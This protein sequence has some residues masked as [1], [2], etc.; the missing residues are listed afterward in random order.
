MQT[1]LRESGEL[2]IGYDDLLHSRPEPSV[3][4]TRDWIE[5]WVDVFGPQHRLLSIAVHEAEVLVGTAVL[6]VKTEGRG[7][8]RRVMFAGQHPTTGEHLDIVARPGFERSVAETVA[9][10]LLGPARRQW[11]VLTM[12]RLRADSAVIPHFIAAVSGRGHPAKVVETGGSPFLPLPASQDELLQTRSRNFRGQVNQS[13][14]RVGRLGSVVLDVLGETLDLDEGLDDLFRLH[15][16]RWGS[17]SGF[18]T[19]DKEAFHRQLAKRLHQNGELYLAVLRVEGRSIAARYDFVYGDK[20]WCVQGGWDPEFQD[21]RPGMYTTEA[22]IRW[23]IDRGLRE[24][25]FL[26][27]DHGYKTRWA[28]ETRSMVTAVAVN[29]Q[30]LRGRG[31][32]RARQD[33]WA[34]AD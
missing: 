17:T 25:D 26:A 20:I 32:E 3:F 13:R 9:D 7:R 1:T 16:M 24:Y 27:G 28:T 6:A 2:P 15:R 31:Y 5:S 22:V 21:A 10:V 12:Q 14:N 4:L 18:A 33:S 30:T 23:G 11:D 34:E 29:R 19:T 8:L